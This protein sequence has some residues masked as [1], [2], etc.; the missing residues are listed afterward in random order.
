MTDQKPLLSVRDLQVYFHLD[1]G[2][3]SRL[4]VSRLTLTKVRYWELSANQVVEN[5]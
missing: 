2:M 4:M 3:L 5:R 1:E